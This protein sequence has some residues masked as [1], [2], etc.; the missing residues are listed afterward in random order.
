MSKSQRP[1]GDWSSASESLFRA[2]RNDHAAGPADRARVR[3]ALGE[4]IA[5]EAGTSSN[6]SEITHGAVHKSTL[7]GKLMWFSAGAA[8][9]VSG[10]LALLHSPDTGPQ[11]GRR[12]GLAESVATKGPTVDGSA[13]TGDADE[14]PSATTRDNAAPSL[15]ITPD[16]T[17][18]STRRDVRD[19][20]RPSP[21]LERRSSSTAA[22]TSA[23][24]E[25]S[26][27]T[28]S[29]QGVPRKTDQ[30]AESERHAGSRRKES[31]NSPE[32]TAEGPRGDAIKP[33]AEMREHDLSAERAE[34]TLV[35]Q[36]QA[37]MRR[38]KPSEALALCAEHERQWP[39]GTFAEEREGVRAI[40][41][42]VL[43]SHDADT[44]ARTFLAAYPRSPLAP[45]VVSACHAPAPAPNSRR[46]N[47]QA[48]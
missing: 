46:T 23:S 2:A 29:S 27:S 15:Q 19:L 37:A 17:R 34:L 40:A 14:I 33:R 9:V 22:P 16:A 3:S 30:V 36:I 13:Y 25:P 21:S 47:T 35:A 1:R 43:R 39:D 28:S 24:A 38:R 4:R 44:R 26:V 11:R 20:R 42:C 8:C 6:A 5:A 48:R 41:S 10:S 7:F 18:A 32:E 45:R 31:S 12:E